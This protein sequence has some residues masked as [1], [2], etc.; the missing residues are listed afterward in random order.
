MLQLPSPTRFTGADRLFATVSTNRNAI[1]EVFIKALRKNINMDRLAELAAAVDDPELWDAVDLWALILSEI[2]AMPDYFQSDT[3]PL[4]GFHL[5]F[6][7]MSY[8]VLS[9]T[10]DEETKT[11]IAGFLKSL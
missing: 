7:Y 4:S 10:L 5:S 3:T 6:V 1:D 11:A 9:S 8:I 2:S